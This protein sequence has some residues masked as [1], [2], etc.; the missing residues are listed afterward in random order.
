VIKTAKLKDLTGQKFGRLTV[1]KHVG[2]DTQGNALWLCKCDCGNKHITTGRNMTRGGTKSCG[3]YH[4]EVVT[5]LKQKDYE[6]ASFNRILSGYKQ[7]ARKRNLAFTLSNDEF[8]KL[9]L[10]DCSYCGRL[11]SQQCT[12]SVNG[13]IVYNGI[14]RIDNTQGYIQGNVKTCCIQCN[15][16]KSDYTEDEFNA[17]IEAVYKNLNLRA[18]S[19]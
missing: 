19:N 13:N 9:I 12:K 14:D 5:R 17:H 6:I 1:I 18:L 4:I 2:T 16:A 10:L 3:C 8:K 7:N 15:Y 11:P